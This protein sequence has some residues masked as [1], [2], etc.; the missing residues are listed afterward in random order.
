MLKRSKQPT[1]PALAKRVCVQ[2][3]PQI[4]L[5]C[6]EDLSNFWCQELP[7]TQYLESPS[8]PDPPFLYLGAAAQEP[9]NLQTETF[10]ATFR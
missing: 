2:K 8:P 10:F 5:Q 6:H 9:R 4:D 7:S 3:T 1:T